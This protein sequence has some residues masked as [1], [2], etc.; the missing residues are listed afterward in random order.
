MSSTYQVP[1]LAADFTVDFEDLLL[2]YLFSKWST[3]DPLKG[4]TPQD[5]ASNLR[6]KP[7]FPDNFKPYEINA[8]TISTRIATRNDPYSWHFFT[9]ME[10]RTTATRLSKD[11]VDPQLGNMER[12][13]ERI[14]NT[15]PQND[16]PG[17]QDMI[18]IGFSRD[19]AG[20]SF[21]Q[22]R[23]VTGSSI[24]SWSSSRWSSVTSFELSYY[25]EIV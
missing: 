4:A 1:N 9:L 15:Y 17:I 18:Y 6:F 13:L 22:T 10:V 8:L 23:A 11:N 25:K 19:Y 3:T 7:G 14:I 2:D 16:I 12:E 24:S 21:A 20:A 5:T